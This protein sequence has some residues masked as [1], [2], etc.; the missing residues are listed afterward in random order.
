M[1]RV[2][3]IALGLG[4]ALAGCGESREPIPELLPVSDF[5]LTSQ[6]GEDFGTHDLRGKVWIADLIF[7]SCPDIC[8]VM[9]ST[10]GNLHRRIDHEDVRFVS[11]TVDPE[12]DTPE[13]LREYAARY[14]ADTDRWVFLT[15]APEDVREVILRSFRLPVEEPFEREDGVRDVLHTSRFMLIDR[16]GVMRGLYE[17]DREGLER[18][19]RDVERL[20]EER[21]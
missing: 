5:T 19:E 8:P 13:V 21:G 9:S 12:V 6:A 14:R 18:L 10:M 16:R 3:I 2:R 17:T 1:R 11:I 4:L 20:L 7:T 15:G